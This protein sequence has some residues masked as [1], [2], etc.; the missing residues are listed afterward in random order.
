MNNFCVIDFFRITMLKRKIN[1]AA[2]QQVWNQEVT[3]AS[4][5]SR[6]Y[7]ITWYYKQVGEIWNEKRE[8]SFPTKGFTNVPVLII[9]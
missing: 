7:R 8:N 4:I 5:L 6:G 3:A 1:A 2:L 9:L